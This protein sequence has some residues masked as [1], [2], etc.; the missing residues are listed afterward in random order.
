MNLGIWFG[1][2]YLV[3]VW[4][5]KLDLGIWF[6]FGNLGWIYIPGLD[7]NTWVGF[8]YLGGQ[9]FS[10]QALTSMSS[11]ELASQKNGATGVSFSPSTQITILSC[12]P[13]YTD[14]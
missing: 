4:I 8:I 12:N 13:R 6:E 3:W 9:G 14:N 11:L 5:P 2:E 1:F 10:L 7:L